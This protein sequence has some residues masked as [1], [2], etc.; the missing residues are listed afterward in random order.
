M[1]RSFIRKWRHRLDFL[2]RETGYQ[3]QGLKHLLAALAFAPAD[4]TPILVL[5]AAP[6]QA[7]YLA[8]WS[9]WISR[10][11]CDARAVADLA[12]LERCLA[13]AAAPPRRVLLSGEL[14]ARFHARLAA[15]VSNG[16][17]AVA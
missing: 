15:E 8:Q 3:A 11:R 16:R 4:G 12:E 1:L 17:L 6:A 2:A 14:Y 9:R 5:V 13:E 10:A 7:R